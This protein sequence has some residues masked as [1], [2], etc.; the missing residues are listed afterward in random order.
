M[1][2]IPATPSAAELFQRWKQI[3]DP[4]TR[5]TASFVAPNHPFRVPELQRLFDQYLVAQETDAGPTPTRGVTTGEPRAPDIPGYTV[6]ADL[7][8]GG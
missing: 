5:T 7:G 4:G 3:L 6:E 2:D 1:T 8:G